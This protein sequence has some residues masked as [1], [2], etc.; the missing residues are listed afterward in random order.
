MDLTEIKSPRG[1]RR[2]APILMVEIV[3]PITEADMP[4]LI[5]PDSLGTAPIPIKALRASHHNLAQL[6][7]RGIPDVEV[8][9]ITGYSQSRIS[10]LKRDPSF[11][12]LMA[13]YK[14]VR[15]H[16]FVDVLERM[17]ILGLSTID[18]LQE[19]LETEPEKWSNR[20]LMELADLLLI[21]PKTAAPGTGQGSGAGTGTVINV[22][23]V[24]ADT[25]PLVIEGAEAKASQSTIQER[26]RELTTRSNS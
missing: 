10:I 25:P 23:F 3:G 16:A 6:L 4:K 22:Q 26:V 12:E 7:S 9:L 5:S 1:G 8:S 19:R 14:E 15:E 18:E 2:P 17:K 24:Q 13:G 20:E 11:A 21:K